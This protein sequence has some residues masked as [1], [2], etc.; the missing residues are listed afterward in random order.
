M[1]RRSPSNKPK[2]ACGGHP[3]PRRAISF[4]QLV[5]EV[6]RLTRPNLPDP[7]VQ[8]SDELANTHARN[9]RRYAQVHFARYPAV[10]EFAPQ[11]LWLPRKYRLGLIAHEL[12]HILAPGKSEAE[13]DRAALRFLRVHITYD[14]R[15]F[16]GKGLQV[17][18]RIR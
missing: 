7:W 12:G 18:R 1:R 15:N 4:N 11:V 17:G 14:K 9:C 3:R 6:L 8:L 10:I 13:A 2:R 5:V 16:P